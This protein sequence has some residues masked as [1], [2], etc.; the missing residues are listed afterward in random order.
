MG[1]GQNGEEDAV[2]TKNDNKA[3][4]G[5]VLD[6]I[7]AIKAHGMRPIHIEA[8][9]ASSLSRRVP[10]PAATSIPTL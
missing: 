10:C 7:E 5:L 3:T 6:D 4:L 1:P 8:T 9:L 2:V